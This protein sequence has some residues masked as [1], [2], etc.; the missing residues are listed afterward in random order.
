VVSVHLSAPARRAPG[1]FILLAVLLAAW[2]APA[3]RA[4]DVDLLAM[5]IEALMQ[6]P[7]TSASGRLVAAPSFTP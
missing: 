7:V 3:A 6:V 2:C 4:A 1:P 5:S